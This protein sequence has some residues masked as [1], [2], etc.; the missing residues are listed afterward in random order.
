MLTSCLTGVNSRIPL[1]F[2]TRKNIFKFPVSLI[3]KLTIQK[4]VVSLYLS[5]CAARNKLQHGHAVVPGVDLSQ[6]IQVR[7]Q[8]SQIPLDYMPFINQVLENLRRGGQRVSPHGFNRISGNN[9]TGPRSSSLN[10]PR[11]FPLWQPV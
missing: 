10:S 7:G 6:V 3:V 1:A 8:R 5:L 4:V 11:C 9:L 2:K